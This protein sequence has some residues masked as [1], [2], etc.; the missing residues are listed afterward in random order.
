M[1]LLNTKP[2]LKRLWTDKFTVVEYQERI[3]PNGATGHQEVIVLEN[4]P[5]KLSF[6]TL[7]ETAQEEMTA[8][9]PQVIKLF[10]DNLIEIKA[11]SKIIVQRDGRTFEYSQSGKPGIFTGH[12]EIVLVP[13]TDWA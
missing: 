2:I 10:F 12:Q 9:A 5:C 13:F 1:M 6:S 4:E 8:T 3:K 11:G 7:K